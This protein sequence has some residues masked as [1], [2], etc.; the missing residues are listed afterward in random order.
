MHGLLTPTASRGIREEMNLL[1]PTRFER[2]DDSKPIERI[3]VAFG[4]KGRAAVLAF[5]GESFEVEDENGEDE[6][7]GSLADLFGEDREGIMVWEGWPKAQHSRSDWEG[8]LDF[9]GWSFVKGDWREPTE[10]E[11]NH[12]RFG[13]NP[14]TEKCPACKACPHCNGT[15]SD[16]IEGCS[17]C[18]GDGRVQPDGAAFPIPVKEEPTEEPIFSTQ[19]VPIHS[20]HLCSRCEGRGEVRNDDDGRDPKWTTKY[21]NQVIG[22]RAVEKA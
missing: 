4:V 12:L 22:S 7:Y 8:A 14:W 2:I 19:F 18:H 3:A 20:A 15:G 10:E 17:P 1:H 16:C 6:F 11:M 21:P 9:D 5:V 13:S